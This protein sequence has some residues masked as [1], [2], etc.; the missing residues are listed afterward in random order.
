MTQRHWNI[1]IQTNSLLDDSYV[2]QPKAGIIK[3]V[4]RAMYPAFK[5]KPRLFYDYE[6]T[7]KPVIFLR[8][9]L[10]IPRF[11]V[12]DDS[13]VEV[14]E[15]KSSKSP[16]EEARLATV[17][18]SR[19]DFKNEES[20]SKTGNTTAEKKSMTITC[21]FPRVV[22]QLDGDRLELSDECKED[23]L[24]GKYG[25]FYASRVELGGH[26]HATEDSA[27]TGNTSASEKAK[28]LKAAASMSFSSPY[29]Q[30]YASASWW[31]WCIHEFG[32]SGISNTGK[33]L[34]EE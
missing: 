6:A 25:C 32:D 9:S 5:L 4:E 34:V 13:Y 2:R 24:K 20:D 11:R 7:L 22:L 14:S 3:K 8:L 18:A 19:V 23:L 33:D 17:L 29:V 26:L 28:T 1:V 16:L 30:A 21:N 10:R 27:A 12:E 31:I 15:N